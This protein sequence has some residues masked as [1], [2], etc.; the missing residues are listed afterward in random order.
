MPIVKSYKLNLSFHN[1]WRQLTHTKSDLLSWIYKIFKQSFNY[2]SKEN[3]SWKNYWSNQT[4]QDKNLIEQRYNKEFQQTFTAAYAQNLYKFANDK[5]NQS[6]ITFYKGKKAWYINSSKSRSKR[7]YFDSIEFPLDY[8]MLTKS[9]LDSNK[10]FLKDKKVNNLYW[11]SI[12]NPYQQTKK[13][14]QKITH[15]DESFIDYKRQINL[16][17][18]IYPEV[19]KYLD[20]WVKYSFSLWDWYIKINFTFSDLQITELFKKQHKLEKLSVDFWKYLSTYNSNWEYNQYNLSKFYKSCKKIMWQIQVLQSQIDNLKNS[21]NFWDDYYKLK[22]EV[23]RLFK[24]ISEKR[25]HTYSFL[26]NKLKQA[27]TIICEDLDFTAIEKSDSSYKWR[28]F[29]KIINLMWKGVWKQ[30]LDTKCSLAGSQ[31]V[32]V[33]PHYTSQQCQSCW[34]IERS[35]RNGRKFH[36]KKCEF[37]FDADMNAAKNIYEKWLEYLLQQKIS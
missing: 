10:H 30:I 31:I 18:Y 24:R 2:I 25:K 27:K 1:N 11:L 9:K 34:H 7:P 14:N 15:Y 35:N 21:R 26:S 5:Y 20:L 17:L 36:C 8:R 37:T 22:S 4:V 6:M 28:S 33:K 19:Q 12:I 32:I 13:L 16:P 23:Q 3:Y 29:N